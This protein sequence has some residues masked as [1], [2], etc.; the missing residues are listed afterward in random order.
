MYHFGVSYSYEEVL[1]FKGSAVAAE[2]D[3]SKLMGISPE[4]NGVIQVDSDNF[5]TNISSQNGLVSTH[6]LALLLTFS[7]DLKISNVL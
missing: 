2:V 1:R 4:S 3:D 6:A 5:D 7:D